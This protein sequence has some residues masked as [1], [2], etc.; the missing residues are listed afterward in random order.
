MSTASTSRRR[1]SIDDS[2]WREALII[3][4]VQPELLEGEPLASSFKNSKRPIAIELLVQFLLNSAHRREALQ[5]LYV[6]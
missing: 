3:Q 6:Q 5:M 4:D 2:Y 1:A